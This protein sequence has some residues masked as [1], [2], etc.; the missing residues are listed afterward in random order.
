VAF[1]H[2]LPRSQPHAIALHSLL[3]LLVLV[4]LVL[5]AAWCGSGPGRLART[6]PKESVIIYCPAR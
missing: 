6:A 4:L 2:A 5:P 1:H 3:V